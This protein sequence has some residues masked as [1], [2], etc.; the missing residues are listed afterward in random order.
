MV[1]RDGIEER[2]G[3]QR[4]DFRTHTDIRI[5]VQTFLNTLTSD[6]EDPDFN[7]GRVFGHERLVIPL[8]FIDWKGD[9]LDG[10]ELDDVR[11]LLGF[12]RGQFRESRECRMP[13]YGHHQIFTLQILLTDQLAETQTYDLVLIHIRFGQNL[14]VSH[15]GEVRHLDTGR[16]TIL[17]PNGLNLV[18]TYFDTPSCLALCHARSPSQIRLTFQPCNGRQITPRNYLNG[19]ETRSFEPRSGQ[20]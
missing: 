13:W 5:H 20:S 3:R 1:V 18:G 6:G 19:T 12:D 2:D 9:L 8:H 10:F 15:D 7:L 4:E 11:N 16:T 17:Q 14:L